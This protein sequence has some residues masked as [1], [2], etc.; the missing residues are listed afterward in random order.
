MG[1]FDTVTC[2]YP[3]PLPEEA[4]Q[5]TNPPDWAAVEFQ[6]KSL[7]CVLDIYSIEEDGQ[8]YKEVVDR[9][10]IQSEDGT[11]TLNETQK[12]IERAD[13]TGEVVFYHMHMESDYDYWAE[14][15]ALF[16]KGDLKEIELSKWDRQDNKQRIEVLEKIQ[17]HNQQQKNAER[18]WWY[19]ARQLYFKIIRLAMFLVRWPIGVIANLTWKIERWLTGGR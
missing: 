4:N 11:L 5:L 18:R 1:M 2:Q 9:E 14:F 19:G 12:G 6:T 17:D 8:V 3:L 7:D 15:K 16:W 13:F 10:V